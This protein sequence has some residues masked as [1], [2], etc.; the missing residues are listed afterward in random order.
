M[1]KIFE[2]AKKKGLKF[3]LFYSFTET[4]SISFDQSELKDLSQKS[5]EGVGLRVIHNGRIGTS[6]SN[7]LND[8]EIIE[9]ALQSSKYAKEVNFDFPELDAHTL[10]YGNPNAILGFNIYYPWAKE[11]IKYLE[12]KYEAKVDLSLTQHKE[13]TKL[14]NYKSD[15]IQERYSNF[16]ESSVSIFSITDS[17]FVMSG[18]WGLKDTEMD[19]KDLWNVVEK[20]E[21]TLLN[22]KRVVKV[23]SGKYKVI[24]T[25]VAT[26]AT[27]GIGLTIGVNGFN[28]ARNRSP[29]KD[30]LNTQILDTKLTIMDAPSDKFPERCEFDDEGIRAKDRAI[31]EN[32][33]LK[34]FLL[35]LDTASELNL[36]PTGN[37]KRSG[38]SPVLSP[39]FH[40]FKIQPG[41]KTL[42]EIIKEQ[43]KAILFIFPIG[44]GQSNLAM[45][46]YSLN[47]GLGYLVEN[48]EVVG[49][50]KDAMV[51]G[52][53][54][55][56][57]KRVIEIS[58]DTELL[59]I[60]S[61]YNLPSIL[62]D[63]VSLTS[64]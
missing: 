50:I 34:G 51:S 58:K 13:K 48:G 38:F 4:R 28:I 57:F 30:K 62:V 26:L 29:L 37:G 60:F 23:P 17:G 1:E 14:A 40:L 55:E 35:D 43:D 15:K 9:F 3:E 36:P 2:V 6:S 11:I 46:D 61:Y 53:I 21:K 16:F 42:E 44:M 20:L 7:D 56:D 18:A 10:S 59:P 8:L 33:V 32:G 47:V 64:K 63:G 5:V 52:N 49:R 54:Y 25:P 39:D 41:E 27:L 45:G 12:S 24:F 19:Q 22:Y 31:V